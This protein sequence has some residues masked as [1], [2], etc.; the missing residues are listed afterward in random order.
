MPNRLAQENSP[1]LLQHKDNPVDWYPWGEEALQK[2]K[3]EDKPIFLSIGY[4]ACHWCHVMEHESFED[5]DTAAIMNEHF[6]NIKV[7]RE[8]RPDID[9]IYMSAVVAMT[10][11]GGWPM[12]MFLTPKGE[13][14]Y[15]GTY[16]PPVRRYQM[17]SF[18][19][20]LHSIADTWKNKRE[21]V[22]ESSKQ[23]TEH[24]QRQAIPLDSSNELSKEALD[25]A[26]FA[27]AQSYDWA[28]GGWGQAPKFPQPMA[29]R[30]LL[31][32]AS[33]GDKMALDV[34]THALRSMAKGGMYDV[35]GGGFAR[36]SVDDIWLVPH[37]EKML[38]DNAQLAR[39]Y[40]W[41]YMLTKDNFFKRICEEALDYVVREMTHEK[42][43]FYSSLDADSEGEEGKFY[44]WSLDEVKEHLGTNAD[45]FIAAY[46][47]S[48]PGNFEGHNILQRV[49]D[50]EAL[51]NQFDLK[52][53]DMPDKLSKLHKTLYEVRSKRVWP[54]TDDKVLV[55]WN[56]W[57]LT[58][59]AEAAR[60]L[61]RGDYLEV[62]RV[63]A[64]FLLNELYKDGRLLRSWR[65]GQ[66]LYNGYL[67]DYA[68]LILGLLALYQSDPDVRW[69][70]EAE[71]LTKEL[72]ENFSDPEGGFFDTRDDHE[73]LLTRPKE[74]QDNA[75]PSGSALAATALFTLAAYSGKGEWYDIA[76]KASAPIQ[77]A[78]EKY[79]TAFA[80]WLCAVNFALGDVQEIAILGEVEG[81]ETKKLQDTL[82]D[83][84]RP[85][86]IAAISPHPPE[87]GA[88]AL[89]NDRP[90]V[91]GMPSAYVCQHFVCKQPVT[92]AEE[93]RSQ[94]S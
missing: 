42:G 68:S 83:E 90:L 32:R 19:E 24:L 34:A 46:G 60:Y 74:I 57:M 21:D 66:A 84:L 72:L 82:W 80:Q 77:A 11:S 10:G 64:D 17:P 71:K 47:V 3:D 53:D 22:A 51:A 29:I 75:T 6:V 85:F 67:E 30:F 26:A 59:F 87:N 15:G 58:A 7:D 41:A 20:V 69:Y 39:V 23:L 92:T 50:D 13:P 63:N 86:S 38:Y 1:Y 48:E 70:S 91:D 37:F 27:L 28:K 56:A 52:A 33:T 8:E 49:L 40:L 62:A 55:S 73:Q 43:G 14:F 79:P 9:G 89:L 12:S 88:P 93:L 65:E 36:Y 61:Q 44:V 4:A 25:K 94:L 16:F 18:Q 76:A 5:P 45:F 81:V 35:V 54:G 2:A 78:I 31:Q